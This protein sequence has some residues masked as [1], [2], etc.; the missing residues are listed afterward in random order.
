MATVP[1]TTFDDQA[2]I[3]VEMIHS[4]VRTFPIEKVQQSA[5]KDGMASKQQ[6][7]VL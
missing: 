4:K 2:M 7:T 3:H 5:I 1:V 6:P